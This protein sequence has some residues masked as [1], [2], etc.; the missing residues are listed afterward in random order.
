MERGN[1][2][3]RCHRWPGLHD[4]D[5]CADRGIP[6]ERRMDDTEITAQR[7]WGMGV[8]LGVWVR[9]ETEVTVGVLQCPVLGEQQYRSEHY[10]C[11]KH[12][13]EQGESSHFHRDTSTASFMR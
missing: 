2:I 11:G 8:A 1:R 13:R 6:I 5:P 7:R 10:A 9:H 4:E 12:I 3:C